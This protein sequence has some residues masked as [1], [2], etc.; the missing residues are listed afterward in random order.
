MT[1]LRKRC[2]SRKQVAGWIRRERAIY[3]WELRLRK[4]GAL[5]LPLI[6][7]RL[8]VLNEEASGVVGALRGHVEQVDQLLERHQKVSCETGELQAK[9]R[10]LSL[11][12][13][14]TV[15]QIP[16]VPAQMKETNQKYL[17]ELNRVCAGAN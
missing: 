11:D 12:N 3:L 6:R 8:D 16:D 7:H 1:A 17:Q 5:K 15:S 4:V 9:V 10:K 14:M 2:L 13:Q